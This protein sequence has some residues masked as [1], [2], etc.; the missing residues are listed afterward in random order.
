MINDLNFRVYRLTRF[1]DVGVLDLGKY[2]MLRFKRSMCLT[3]YLEHTFPSLFD[4]WHNIQLSISPR[5]GLVGSLLQTKYGRPDEA[6][7]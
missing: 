6:G 4:I 1:A 7:E 5:L 2:M 3:A